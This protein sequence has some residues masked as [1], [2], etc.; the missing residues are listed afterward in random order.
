MCLCVRVSVYAHICIHVF[1]CVC[2]C[3]STISAISYHA[4]A[5][6]P[7]EKTTHSPSACLKILAAEGLRQRILCEA[8]IREIRIRLSSV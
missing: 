5:Y 6:Y 3:V 7:D 2:M 1:V 4:L 8:S